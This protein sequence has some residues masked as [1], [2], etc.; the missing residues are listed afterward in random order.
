MV[1][2]VF[3]SDLQSVKFLT[4]VISVAP[5]GVV[6]FSLI[7]KG[8]PRKNF[9]VIVTLLFLLITVSRCYIIIP[10]LLP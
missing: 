3:T 8:F 1:F 9:G 5:L 10:L 6:V 2:G 7:Q 4:I